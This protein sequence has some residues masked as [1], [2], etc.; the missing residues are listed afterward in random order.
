VD[1]TNL[2]VDKKKLGVALVY[3]GKTYIDAN[4][5]AKKMITLKAYKAE[6]NINQTERT[7]EGYCAV[8]GNLDEVGDILEAGSCTKTLQERLPKQEIKG[9][10]MHE[11]PLGMPIEMYADQKGVYVKAKVSKTRLG[12]EAIELMLDKVVDRMSIGYDTVKR[13]YEETEKGIIRRLLEIKL[14]EFSPVLFPANPAAAITGVKDMK[15]VTWVNDK[16][17]YKALI[18]DREPEPSTLKTYQPHDLKALAESITARK[19][20]I[21]SK[22]QSY[23]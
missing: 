9:L 12:D 14:Y 11:L 20:I 2:P 17:E 13:Q 8:F 16:A 19:N 21:E 10:W 15:G 5:Q 23:V 3:F 1:A 22:H 18:G 4:N 7:F 6:T